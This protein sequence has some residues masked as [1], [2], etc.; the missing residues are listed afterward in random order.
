MLRRI[1]WA[2][3]PVIATRV[4][5]KRRGTQQTRADKMRYKGRNGR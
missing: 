3:V 5:N 1:L 4:L 2:L